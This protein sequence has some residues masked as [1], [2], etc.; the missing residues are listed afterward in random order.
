M[1]EDPSMQPRQEF[2]VIERDGDIAVYTPRTFP[3]GTPIGRDARRLGVDGP[4]RVRPPKI[5]LTAMEFDQWRH[6]LEEAG[7]TVTLDLFWGDPDRLARS[8]E[9][10]RRGETVPL[11]EAFDELLREADRR[12]QAEGQ[13]ME[14]L[15]S[16]HS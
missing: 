8:V 16:R 13:R 11:K 2:L 9:A 12:S 5:H 7:Y 10:V 6:Q 4:S 1:R 15:E 14:S 3:M